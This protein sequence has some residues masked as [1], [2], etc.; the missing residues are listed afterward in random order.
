ML[1]CTVRKRLG[2]FVLDVSFTAAAGET[3][4]V[5]GESGSGKS[6]LLRTLAGLE[7][8]DA[9]TIALD[10]TEWFNGATGLWL[11]PAGRPVGL[12]T[13]DYALFPHLTVLE[14]V[15]FGLRAGGQPAIG[16]RRRALDMLDRIGIGGLAP[17]R[18]AALSGGQQQRVALARA[19]VLDPA[20]LLLDEPLSALDL[21]TRREVRTELRAILASLSC[22]TMYVT[23]SPFEALA[24]GRHIAVLDA[25]GL[26]QWGSGTELL[27]HPRSPYVAEFMG[28]NFFQGRIE[29]RVDGLARVITEEGTIA[30]TDPGGDDDVFL[31]VDPREITLH[32]DS[33]SGSMQNVFR[34]RIVELIA[35][36][37]RGER[38]RVILDTRPPLVAEVTRPAAEL[39]G[40][41]EGLPV[42]ATFKAVG[43][44]V[45][46]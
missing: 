24:F 43:V 32:V 2:S 35:E 33:P 13:Q 42:F 39:L 22:V 45:Y 15:A 37:P 23:H 31:A 30:A 6:T 10:Q 8:P 20:L 18:P 21:Q 7:R 3:L 44:T 5:V 12:V 4:V 26:A 40:L 14:N 11:P 28:L 41:R 46:R 36:P 19:L 34:G 17:R 1:R 16:A 9:G 25:G 38:L 29:S 27:R